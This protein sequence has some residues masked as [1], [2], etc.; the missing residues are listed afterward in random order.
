MKKKH[1]EALA[2]FNDFGVIQRVTTDEKIFEEMLP[3]YRAYAYFCL[4]R[5]QVILINKFNKNDQIY[6]L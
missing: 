2:E 4:S 5:Y 6:L 1:E 3:R